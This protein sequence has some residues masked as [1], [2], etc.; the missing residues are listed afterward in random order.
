M[1]RLLLV[2]H[3]E[4]DYNVQTRFQGQNDVELNDHGK[5]QAK[6]L[7]EH[8]AQETIHSVFS[9]D[10]VR[11]HQTTKIITARKEREV[12]LDQ[13]LREMDFGDWEGLTYAEI[14]QNYPDE[15]TVWQD[16]LMSTSPPGGETLKKFSGRVNLAVKDIIQSYTDQNVLIVSHG[17]VLQVILCQAIGLS[18]QSHWQFRLDLASISE[19]S[20]Y[21][22]GTI[23]NKLNNTC[24]LEAFK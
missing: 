20:I 7:G 4:T 17:G 3:G 5:Q 19:I 13:R 24:H 6:A 9:S 12:I 23:L 1:T 16:D 10:L 14:E 11:A 21:S 18:P 22:E 2:R 8:L 15:L